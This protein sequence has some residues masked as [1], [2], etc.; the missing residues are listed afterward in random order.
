[1]NNSSGV[2][3]EP[4]LQSSPLYQ[5]QLDIERECIATGI[6]KYNSM[7]RSAEKRM[8]HGQL[9]PVQAFIVYWIEATAKHIGE[10][11]G[12]YEQHVGGIGSAHW[13]PILR[14]LDRDRVAVA[15][16]ETMMSEAL[17]A[18][19]GVRR[20]SLARKIGDRLCAELRMDAIREIDHERDREYLSRV[21]SERAVGDPSVQRLPDEQSLVLKLYR[22]F[23]TVNAKRVNRYTKEF[24]DPEW[25]CQKARF[26]AGAALMRIVMYRAAS[27]PTKN[28]KS[29]AAFFEKKRYAGIKK[30]SYIIPSPAM[31]EAMEEWH[32]RRAYLRPKYLPMVIEPLAWSQ[33]PDGDNQADMSAMRGGYV[34]LTYPLVS[35]V[36]PEQKKAIA[37]AD[38]TAFYEHFNLLQRTPWSVNTRI[39]DVQKQ[40][41]AKGGNMLGIPRMD[42]RPLPPKPAT[43]DPATINLWLIN[44]RM[45]RA[46]NRDDIGSREAW[47]DIARTAEQ[48]SKYEK[49]YF[50]WYL[51][52]RSRASPRPI[53]LNHHNHDAVR[54]LLLF[55][56]KKPLNATGLYWLKVRAANCWGNDKVSNDERM[57]WADDHML[58][59]LHCAMRPMENDWWMGADEPWQFLATCMAF[60]DPDEIGSR[61]WVPRDGTCNALQWYGALTRDD[62]LAPMVN[63]VRSD[64]PG[65]LYSMVARETAIKA[66]HDI[67]SGS[68]W[69]G[70]V[71]PLIG[72]KTAKPVSMPWAY[73]M[74]PIG[75]KKAMLK[76]L[77]EHID[78]GEQLF[79]CSM[80]LAKSN[81][82]ATA[83][84]CPGAERMKR[85]VAGVASE[86]AAKGLALQWT[87]PLGF[88][89]VQ[90]YRRR[91]KVCIET[92]M[93]FFDLR[94]PNDTLPVNRRGQATAAPPNLIHCLDAT[95]MYMAAM[96]AARAGIDYAPVHDSHWTHANDVPILNRLVAETFVSL[97][98]KNWLE[99][100]RWQLE[101]YSGLKLPAP[102]EWGSLDLSGIASGDS[103]F[104]N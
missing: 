64:K 43:D 56:N 35:S 72:R 59:M 94:T 12:K 10:L 99:D 45:V 92:A 20:T 37:K 101:Q 65:D 83:K 80:Y 14:S 16:L 3:S 75:A 76:A 46:A 79:K 86:V 48:F 52:F 102:P 68:T 78:D 30:T 67:M 74:T 38:L 90:P 39:L 98:Q 44:R 32:D 21:E 69:A 55:G 40:A 89:V 2:L 26:Q 36:M 13:G 23:R 58:D 18:P 4:L 31:I 53:G 95:H 51:D 100:W 5:A 85:W 60:A 63:L 88:P 15:V 93:G 28:G 42:A 1:M 71:K 11:V 77:E 62:H 8:Q 33:A 7:R 66:E 9:K 61:M 97:N 29:I 54:G 47:L 87:T 41:M 104:L 6:D 27:I 70:M 19:S 103:Y 73:G 34:G 57:K 81:I 50:P 96:E 49:M 82:V 91:D 17:S 84:V 25:L 24:Y 22:R